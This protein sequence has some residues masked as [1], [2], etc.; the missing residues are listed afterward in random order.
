M[1]EEEEEQR[2]S[3]FL[4]VGSF[5][6]HWGFIL[7]LFC[8]EGGYVGRWGGGAVLDGVGGAGS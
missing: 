7:W 6:V 2:E 5:N 4:V 8:V 1:D 3:D